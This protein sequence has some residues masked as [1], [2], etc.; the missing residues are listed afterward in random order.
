LW[1]EALAASTS[2]TS[3]DVETLESI[4]NVE[5]APRNMHDS[6]SELVLPFGSSKEFFEQYTNAWGGIRTGKCVI[7][8]A[9]VDSQIEFIVLFFAFCRLMEH[10]DSLAGSITYKHMLGPVQSVGNLEQRGFYIVTASVDRFVF[11]NL[12]FIV[13]SSLA[14]FFLTVWTCYPRSILLE[15]CD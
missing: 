6:Y 2:G 14:T 12:S 15:T 4:A 8:V 3:V 9:I 5:L 13:Q 11:S 7:P 1:A 10:L